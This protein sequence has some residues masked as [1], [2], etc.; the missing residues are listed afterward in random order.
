MIFTSAPNIYEYA[1][2]VGFYLFCHR[3]EFVNLP[4]GRLPARSKDEEIAKLEKDVK[5]SYGV[6]PDIPTLL[7]AEVN[8]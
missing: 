3:H 1:L 7:S 2:Y 5:D 8:S 4:H 6:V